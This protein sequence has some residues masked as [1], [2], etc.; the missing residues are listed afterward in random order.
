MKPT[1]RRLVTAAFSA[2]LLTSFIPQTVHAQ[3]I[4]RATVGTQSKDLGKQAIAFL[5]NELWIHAGD[6][7]TWTSASGDIHTVS[8]LIAGQHVTPFTVGCPGY[9]VSGVSFDGSTCVSAPPLVLG[10]EFNVRFPVAGNFSLLCLVH[11]HMTGVIHVLAPSAPLPHGQA[12]YDE[13]AERQSRA[14]LKDADSVMEHHGESMDSMFS[15]RVLPGH[16]VVAGVGEMSATNAGFQSLSVMRFM[17]ATIEVREGDTVEWR[18]FDPATP[19]TVT[20]GTE[21]L[22][23]G[24]PSSNVTLDLDGARHAT[25]SSL[26]DS[27]HSGLLIPGS[28]NRIGVPQSP[29]P[30]TVFRVTF[31]EPGTYDYK[32]ALHDNLGMVGKV[33]VHP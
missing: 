11:P 21:P 30:S 24:P 31:T 17:G 22:N 9:S 2:F 4:W 8:L 14:L 20:F 3:Q 12:F 19:H 28:E 16:G 33:I 7:I 15:A 27:V 29:P 25:V 1:T 10:Q 32:C 26:H 6:S 23:P 5:P 13:Q 18:N